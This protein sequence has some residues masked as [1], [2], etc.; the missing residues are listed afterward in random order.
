MV[1]IVEQTRQWFRGC[2]GLAVDGTPRDSAFCAYTI[3]GRNPLIVPDATK[4]PRFRDNPLVVG[5]PGIRFYAG[6][7]LIDGD[8]MALGSFCVVHTEPHEISAPQ[9]WALRALAGLV[10]ENITQRRTSDAAQASLATARA[11]RD[12]LIAARSR[13][14]AEIAERDRLVVRLDEAV[15]D[16]EAA[17]RAKS[18]F[19]ANMSHEVRTPMTAILGYADLIGAEEANPLE[20][21]E[22]RQAIESIQRNGRHLLSIINDVLDYSKVEAG[23]VEAECISTPIRS[24][25][26][27]VAGTLGER[28]ACPGVTVAI[29]H[30][31]GVPSSIRTDP[32]LLR[33]VL[34]NLVGNALKFTSAGAVTIRTSV[35]TGSAGSGVESTLR[36]DVI[37]TGIGIEA[38]RLKQLFQ[39]FSQ[40][41]ASFARQYG[42][43]GLGLCISAELAKLLGGE[44]RAWS[45]PGRGSRFAVTI[46]LVACADEPADADTVAEVVQ[47][48]GPALDGR[49][50]LLVE[51]GED[52]RRLI[53]HHLKK[54][55]AVVELASNGVAGVEA[56]LGAAAETRAF[57]LIIM[58]IQMP[59]LD[60]YGATRQLR[61]RR[62]TTPIIALT[63]H[64][65]DGE[66]ERCLKSGCD[67][68][69]TKPIDASVLLDAC[70]RWI[71]RGARGRHAA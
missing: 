13:L 35:R 63:A 31:R 18:V 57:D 62:I 49:R 71:E 23:R 11:E 15:R 44:I 2:H 61:E 26:E 25:I 56:V 58:D 43:T 17:N 68:Y 14:E 50:V 27:Q 28:M 60:G 54:A 41:D 4:D 38:A 37:D 10:L 34:L 67:D 45:E 70:A 52:N 19:L 33:Q 40:A 29:E 8:G 39:P 12:A 66:R 21:E 48:S 51:D 6:I 59:V 32:T 69:L 1:S 64:A 46:P 65:M 16:A 20:P 3:M 24:L 7:P 47:P 55:G 22:H 30:G 9:L 53:G 42:G 5:K 36:I